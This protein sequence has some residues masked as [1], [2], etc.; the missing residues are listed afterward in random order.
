MQKIDTHCHVFNSKIASV[1]LL[2]DII[3][4]IL[5][6]S[7]MAAG[8][9][10]TEELQSFTG[11]AGRIGEL[12]KLLFN[13]KEDTLLDYISEYERDTVFVPLMFDIKYAAYSKDAIK[14]LQE[15]NATLEEFNATQAQ[16][17]LLQSGDEEGLKMLF[18][19]IEAII[20]ELEEPADGPVLLAKG[21]RD[22]FDRQYEQL[23]ALRKRHPGIIKPFFAVDSRRNNV[24]ALMVQAIEK[25][26]FAGVK[27]YCPNG[28][29]PLDPRLEPVYQY[30]LLNNIPITA[31][32][33]YGGFAT[34]ENKINVNGAIYKNNKV[35]QFTG[36]LRFSKKITAKGGVEERAL[37]L[38][39]PALW[40]EVLQK[41]KGLKLN[42][43][44]FGIK[45]GESME[46]RFEWS[47]LILEMMLKHENLY[48][49]LSCM[50]DKK[51]ITHLWELASNADQECPF[52]L[53]ITDRILFGTD[54]WLSMIFN[55]MEEY[56]NN[57]ELVFA[58]KQEDLRKIQQINPRRFLNNYEL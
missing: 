7:F 24:Y 33:S 13:K 11:T 40:D 51:N 19:E 10:T 27:L 15:M 18:D 41:Y 12:F 55:D 53:K 30:C 45:G 1:P 14:V 4:S 22:T 32:C 28:Y 2:L 34:L 39:H 46:E 52:D 17:N 48:T 54:F 44:H 43:A 35:Q 5:T 29:S 50:T 25:E 9:E 57:F 21:P 42:L 38:N 6:P 58:D 36:E 37:A 16:D 20:E 8:E 23:I 31:H 26:N 3:K 49:D 56:M 47:N